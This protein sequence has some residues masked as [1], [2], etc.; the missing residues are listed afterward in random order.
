ME[1]MGYEKLKIQK[2]KKKKK[3]KMMTVKVKEI[4][5]SLKENISLHSEDS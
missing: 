3:K 5:F 2:K 4:F 1:K